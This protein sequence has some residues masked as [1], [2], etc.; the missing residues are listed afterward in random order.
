MA[1]DAGNPWPV[2][3]RRHRVIRRQH[4]ERG[5]EIVQIA[6]RRSDSKKAA[7]VLHHVDAGP[8]IARIDHQLHR[9]VRTRTSR[10]AR[11]PRSGSER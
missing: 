4:A 9:A 8:A 11:R 7:I 6:I 1:S 10:S 2:H 5:T 3:Q